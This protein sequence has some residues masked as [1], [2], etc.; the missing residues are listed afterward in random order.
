MSDSAAHN[1]F[2]AHSQRRAFCLLLIGF[3]LGCGPGDSPTDTLETLAIGAAS[4]ARG[5]VSGPY[6]ETLSASGGDANYAWSVTSGSLPAGLTLVP[7][8]GTIAGTPTVDGNTAFTVS[9]ASGDGQTATRNL[10]I[11]VDPQPILAPDELCSASPVFAIATFAAS[12]LE[13][14]VRAALGVG[15]ADLLTCALLTGVTIVSGEDAG[16]TSLSGIQNLVALTD[17][18]VSGNMISDLGPLS[19]LT[20]LTDLDLED[21]LIVGVGPLG[22]LVGLVDLDLEYNSIV[23]ISPLATLVELLEFDLDENS[24]SDIS[25]LSTLTKITDLNID[26]N[27]ISDI[28]VLS[29]LTELI[30]L[31]IDH[32]TIVDISSLMMLTK[33]IDL[34]ADSNMIS[35]IGPLAGLTTL[36]DVDL[37]NNPLAD[38]AALTNLT[39][40]FYLGLSDTQVSDIQPLLNN[41]GLGSGDTVDL[42]LTNVSCSDAALLAAKGVTVVHEGCPPH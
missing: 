31:D 23:D 12:S 14:A 19:G 24:I 33:L 34:E 7:T 42:S 3:A 37:D 40:L 26:H 27:T 6:S 15:P 38:I 28:S 1:F 13:D 29:G 16:I 41:T 35:D 30:D 18:D 11:D 20:S 17:L 5:T 39:N 25:A 9:V 36:Q 21:N 4:L 32:N 8:S 22:S 2:P 10:T